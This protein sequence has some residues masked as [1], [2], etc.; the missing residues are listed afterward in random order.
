MPML[1]LVVQ[2]SNP[3]DGNS[4]EMLFVRDMKDCRVVLWGKDGQEQ[5]IFDGG[6]CS[7]S[8]VRELFEARRAYEAKQAQLRIQR[9]QRLRRAARHR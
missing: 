9:N 1:R 5:V 3:T 2:C 8:R 7:E 6:D 4:Q